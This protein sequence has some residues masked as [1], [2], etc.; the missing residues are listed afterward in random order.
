MCYF[1]MISKNGPCHLIGN[2][3]YYH[4]KQHDGHNP[5]YY[6]GVLSQNYVAVINYM[7]NHLYISSTGVDC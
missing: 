2:K 5:N 4:I 7:I 1:L 3:L 6:A